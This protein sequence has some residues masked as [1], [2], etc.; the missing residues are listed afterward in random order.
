MLHWH[1]EAITLATYAYE[2]IA[3]DDPV[4]LRY[5]EARD[6]DLVKGEQHLERGWHKADLKKGSSQKSV[7]I[8]KTMATAALPDL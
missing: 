6:F 5:F 2:T 3:V 1:Y 4:F 8:P 7:D